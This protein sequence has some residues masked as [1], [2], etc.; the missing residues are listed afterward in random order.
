MEVRGGDKGRVGGRCHLDYFYPL[1]D[2]GPRPWP[3]R[4]IE[5]CRWLVV[6]SAGQLGQAKIRIGQVCACILAIR[7]HNILNAQSDA[8][9]SKWQTT[10]RMPGLHHVFFVLNEHASSDPAVGT[11]VGDTM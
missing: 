6:L 8:E 10:H 2:R 4:E 11:K 3:T 1:A 9:R 5:T 7:H